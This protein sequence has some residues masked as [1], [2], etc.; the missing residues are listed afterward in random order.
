[1]SPPAKADSS[2]APPCALEE[3]LRRSEALGQRV[4]DYIQLM[5]QVDSRNGTSGEAKER[6]VTAFYERLATLESQ[7]GRIQEALRLG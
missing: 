3:G 1:M 5:C 6:A 2:P 4:N 7:L